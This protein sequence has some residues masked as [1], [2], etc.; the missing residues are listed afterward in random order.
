M[1]K[2]S[3]NQDFKG[4]WSYEPAPESTDHVQIKSQYDL[5]IDGDFV[6]PV[7][8]GYFDSINPSNGKKRC[9]VGRDGIQQRDNLLIRG[10]LGKIAIV[11]F[12]G[13]ECRIT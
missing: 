4:L 12:D 2:S 10:A 11:I 13:C 1:S 6:K 3:N 5:F 7:K 8:A 9:Q